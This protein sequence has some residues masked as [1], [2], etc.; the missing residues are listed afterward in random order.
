MGYEKKMGEVN[1]VIR[2]SMDYSGYMGTAGSVGTGAAGTFEGTD[3]IQMLQKYLP[4]LANVGNGEVYLYP[5][6]RTFRKEITEI[7]NEGI[8]MRN[9]ME[10]MR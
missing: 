8:G 7:A 10:R 1:R 6:R 3:I 4:Y 5:G 9:V 2:D